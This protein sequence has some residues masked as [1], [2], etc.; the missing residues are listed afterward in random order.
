[1]R[2]LFLASGAALLWTLSMSNCLEWRLSKVISWALKKYTD[3]DVK[4]YASIL[5]LAGGYSIHEIYVQRRIGW[6]VAS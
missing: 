1:M 5:H 2:V 4:D 6:P 3:L